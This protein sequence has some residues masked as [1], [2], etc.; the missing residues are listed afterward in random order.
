MKTKTIFIIIFS[1]IILI[2]FFHKRE[3]HKEQW[4]FIDTNETLYSLNANDFW[5][6]ST[7]IKNEQEVVVAIIDTG[8]DFMHDALKGNIWI[9][10]LEIENDGIDNDNNGYV[11]DIYGW[12]FIDN[13]NQIDTYE[14]SEHENDHGTFIAGIIASN[15]QTGKCRGIACNA[16]L[17][18]MPLEV[19]GNSEEQPLIG[20]I[21][22]ILKAI[23]YAEEN[24]AKI[25]NFSINIDIDD[26]RLKSKIQNSSL[27]FVVSAGNGDMRGLNIDKVKTYPAAY[28]FD[29]VIVVSSINEKGDLYS[30]SNYGVNT[31]D[32]VAPGTDI[33]STKAGN[34][35]GI[36]T[37]TSY[38]T[39]FVTGVAAEIYKKDINMMAI[40]CKEII[41]NSAT[42]NEHIDDR[43]K[44]GG[45]LNAYECMLP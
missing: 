33:Y 16:G 14:V 2:K 17:Q 15:M 43:V 24:G 34:S 9:N 37:G 21:E 25:C 1:F 28:M 31:V 23:D 6:V 4:Y 39:A 18:I 32:I 42:Y 36:G 19:L 10:S 29:N 30:K 40:R 27:L 7:R 11:D 22:N 38:A 26:P 3:F 44:N 45:V 13:N 5:E 41:C 12:N 8:I 35:Y 20:D